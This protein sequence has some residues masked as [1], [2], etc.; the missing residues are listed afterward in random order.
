MLLSNLIILQ[1]DE[2]KI[3]IAS[4]TLLICETDS[5][6]DGNSGTKLQL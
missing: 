1:S 5:N 3:E 2:V 4:L 6:A